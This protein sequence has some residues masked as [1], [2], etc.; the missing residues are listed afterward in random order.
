LQHEAHFTFSS[1]TPWLIAVSGR[2]RSEGS[3][4]VRPSIAVQ[5]GA[6]FENGAE[7]AGVEPAKPA[8]VDGL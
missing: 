4:N 7:R 6:K 2:I 3:P 8:R 5:N 1:L